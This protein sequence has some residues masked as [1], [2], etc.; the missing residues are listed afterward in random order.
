M[1]VGI[2]SD[3]HGCCETWQ[4]VFSKY[5]H[6]VDLIIH[7]GDVLYHGPRNTIPPE[8]DPKQLAEIINN[9]PVPIVTACGNCDAAVDQM[10]LKI[11]IQSPY[12]YIV[13]NN[14][15]IVV[16]HGHELTDTAKSELAKQFKADL[17]ITGHSHLPAL[18]KADDIV[19]LNPG[20]PGMSK[21]SDGH[22]TIALL[23]KNIVQVLDITNE[24]VLFSEIID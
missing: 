6:D 17:F 5:F 1:K 4:K 22:G 20:S 19:Y 23:T 10:V 13:L 2:I 9:C 18:T 21:R 8:Y 11:P 12:A 7:A 24:K 3:T 15:R 14:I 16:T